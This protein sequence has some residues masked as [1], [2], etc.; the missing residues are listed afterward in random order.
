MIFKLIDGQ[1]R[2]TAYF[3][4]YTRR[5]IV[6]LYGKHIRKFNLRNKIEIDII[7]IKATGR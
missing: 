1:T 4:I 5:D 7:K 3:P 2:V 6:G